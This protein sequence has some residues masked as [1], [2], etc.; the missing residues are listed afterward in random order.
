MAGSWAAVARGLATQVVTKAAVVGMEMAMAAVVRG[1]ER[2][3][4]AL[5]EEVA[6]AVA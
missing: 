1:E 5:L 2:Q 6:R 4:K 3:A